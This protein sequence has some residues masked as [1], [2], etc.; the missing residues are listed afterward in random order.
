MNI[1]TK[2][3]LEKVKKKD[4]KFRGSTTSFGNLPLCPVEKKI[5]GATTA[6]PSR[7]ASSRSARSY[8]DA[9]MSALFI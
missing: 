7:K 8:Y 5:F 6:V 2:F 4:Q 9:L 1:F 3:T